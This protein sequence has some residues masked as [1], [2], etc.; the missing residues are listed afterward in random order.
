MTE[1]INRN[2]RVILRI[3]LKIV[4]FILAIVRD[5]IAA[6]AVVC[7]GMLWLDVVLCKRMSC[8][9]VHAKCDFVCL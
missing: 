9:F 1:V 7:I 6:I 2:V 3:V 5:N 4:S 8:E